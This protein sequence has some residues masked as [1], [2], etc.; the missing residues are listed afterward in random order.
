MNKMETI[1]KLLDRNFNGSRVNS[2]D[3]LIWLIRH[4]G[5]LLVITPVIAYISIVIWRLY[6]KPEVKATAMELDKQISVRV[7]TLET[8]FNKQ[9]RLL[10]DTHYIVKKM[11]LIQSRTAPAKVVREAAEEVAIE[12]ELDNY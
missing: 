2:I 12:K 3:V 5:F 10:K 4:T 1:N 6:M 11:E 7:D 8:R 9:K